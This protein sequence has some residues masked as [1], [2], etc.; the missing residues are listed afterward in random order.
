M[1]KKRIIFITREIVPFYYG[2]IGTQFKAVA[3]FLKRHGH[4]VYFL[5]QKHDTFDEVIY[6]RNYGDILLF[7]VDAPELPESF[8]SKFAYALEVS[9]KFDDIYSKIYPDI[10]ICAD[11][12][13]ES[14][15]LFLKSHAGEYENTRFILT[16]NGLSYNTISIYES[17]VNF[18]QQSELNDPQNIITCEME[19]MSV[20]LANEIVAPTDFVWNEVKNRLMITKKANI[21]PNFVDV[22][23]FKYHD[24]DESDVRQNQLILFI[25]RLDR[26]KGADFLIKAYLDMVEDLSECIPQLIFIGRDIYWKEYE[27]TFLEYW[28]KRIPSSCADNII[29]L[30][31]IDH[32]QIV[33]YLNQATVCVFPSRWDVFGIV[34]LEAMYCGCPVLVSQGTGLEE[35]LGPSLSNYTFDVNKGEDALEQKL[36]SIL[37]NT[38]QIKK[39]KS[40]IHKR[41]KELI[42]MGEYC[43]LDLVEKGFSG[44]SKSDSPKLAPFYGKLFQLL[45]ALDDVMFDI[46]AQNKI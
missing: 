16:I 5:T 41:A 46:G 42:N 7:F 12:G 38:T 39:L 36:I 32:D 25:G 23:M 27:S 13:A 28:Q 44:G 10:V 35:V 31:Q 17:G 22:D 9:K 1:Q 19:D 18:L 30:G 29:F 8:P 24:I 34:C 21:I 37:Q 4:E 33:N 6:K 2:G 14:Y 43:L 11:Y 26:I 40:E 15:F 20:L 45:S 3:K